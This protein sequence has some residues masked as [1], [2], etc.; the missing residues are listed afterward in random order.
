M[1]TSQSVED[2]LRLD[3]KAFV[4]AL[5]PLIESKNAQALQ[6]L[7][8][9]ESK[10]HSKLAKKALYQLKSSGVDLPQAA[11]VISS[12][13]SVEEK[14]NEF[15]A[16]LSSVL[17]TGE[18][19]IFFAVPVR[20]GPGLEVFQGIIS[21][22]H[23]LTQLDVLKSNRGLYR[24]RMREL[25]NEKDLRVLKVSFARMALELRRA[26]KLNHDSATNLPA[27]ALESLRKIG[28]VEPAEPIGID[29]LQSTDAEVAQSASA[30]HIEKEIEQWLPSQ[31]QLQHLATL[32]EMVTSGPLK[33]AKDAQ[34]EKIIAECNKLSDSTF[35]ERTRKL[36]AR[37]LYLMAE[38]FEATAR[39]SQSALARACARHLFHTLET[40]AFAREMFVKIIDFEAIAKG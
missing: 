40:S 4:L 22:E 25:D 21:D 12:V 10:M 37:R 31:N 28:V 3:E 5:R 6:K 32:T 26:L 39:P 24:Q 11:P 29:A 2:I 34:K 36:Y 7:S 13:G 1:N 15:E 38:V 17:G 27:G 19:A 33:L 16:V 8:E 9:C 23:G 18:R 30:L 20:G 14:A 35:N